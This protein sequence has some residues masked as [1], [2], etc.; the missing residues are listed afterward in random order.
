VRPLAHDLAADAAAAG[1]RTV[2]TQALFYEAVSAAVTGHAEEARRTAAAN[3]HLAEGLGPLWYG[4]A[5]YSAAMAALAD[6]DQRAARQSFERGWSTVGR[7][8]GVGDHGLAWWPRAD[9]AAGDVDAARAHAAEAL[10]RA[11]HHEL[12]WHLVWALNSSALVALVADDA[13]AAE[14]FT[15]ESLAA[16]EAVHDDSC[17]ADAL[18]LLALIASRADEMPAAARFAG[19]AAAIARDLGYI[20]IPSERDRYDECAAQLREAMGDDDFRRAWDEGAALSLDEAVSYASRG[21]GQRKRPSTGWESLT[22][23]ERDVAGLVGEGL[24]NKDIAAKVFVSPRA[25]QAHL[26]H[27]YAK[28]GIGSRVDLAREVTRRS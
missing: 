27:I 26:T 14:A 22:P 1:E 23:A 28:L 13:A 2:L 4:I 3:V 10:A 16:N 6:G 12:K 9:L 11:R 5:Q 8:I 17:T 18:W 19:A 15:Y 25:V 7:V 20:P 21:R 24:T